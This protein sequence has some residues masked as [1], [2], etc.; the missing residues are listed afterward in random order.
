MSVHRSK[1]IA[2]IENVKPPIVGL[3][4]VETAPTPSHPVPIRTREGAGIF[5]TAFDEGARPP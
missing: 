4:A 5:P 2:D 1:D 3:S